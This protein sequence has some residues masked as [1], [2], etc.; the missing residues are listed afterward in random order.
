MVF[1]R[2]NKPDFTIQDTNIPLSKK[3][4]TMYNHQ[5]QH[6]LIQPQTIAKPQ[7]A[8]LFP[9]PILTNPIPT[10]ISK[11]GAAFT[12]L[13]PI[14]AQ[15]SLQDPNGPAP[16]LH[17]PR[18]EHSRTETNVNHETQ[19]ELIR[20]GTRGKLQ[21]TLI[22]NT[23]ESD[24]VKENTSTTPTMANSTSKLQSNSHRSTATQTIE[25]KFRILTNQAPNSPQ[26]PVSPNTIKPWPSPSTPPLNQHHTTSNSSQN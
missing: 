14:V 4:N 25:T 8:P 5:Q 19:V 11:H 20:R 2:T 7:P 6:L 18:L 3:A 9:K 10:S 26:F 1:S 16:R 24:G 22:L 21:L 15:V 17:L 12:K 23:F 13:T